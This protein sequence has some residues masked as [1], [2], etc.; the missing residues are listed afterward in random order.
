[1]ANTT[2]Q[3]IADPVAEWN[4]ADA[5]GKK[6]LETIFGKAAFQN[7][8]NTVK[9]IEDVY[10]VV[11]KTPTKYLPK[12]VK[13]EEFVKYPANK[14]ELIAKVL[15]EGWKPDWVNENER[16][17]WPWFEYNKKQKAFSFDDCDCHYSRSSVGSRLC[18]KSAEL[19]KYAA[20]QFIAEYNEFLNL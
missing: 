7:I 12:D 10:A 16:K 8:T 4:R 13:L 5:K 3:P 2:L 18:F 20:T 1:M 17:Y 11:C 6:V 19:A 9:T 14:I 15:N